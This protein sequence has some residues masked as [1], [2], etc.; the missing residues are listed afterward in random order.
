MIINEYFVINFFYIKFS[1][2]TFY[3]IRKHFAALFLIFLV[4]SGFV[5]YM[6]Q[7]TTEIPVVKSTFRP[8]K[9]GPRNITLTESCDK[10]GDRFLLQNL[11]KQGYH[12]QASDK[13][14]C[15]K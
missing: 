7:S 4:F 2:P 9:K 10:H 5:D 1:K 11:N 12:S 3:I 14:H 15:S 13:T 6:T 8:K